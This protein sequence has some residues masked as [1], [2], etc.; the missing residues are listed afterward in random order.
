MLLIPPL[1]PPVS[2]GEVNA[3]KQIIAKYNLEKI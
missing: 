1:I 3:Y 2:K